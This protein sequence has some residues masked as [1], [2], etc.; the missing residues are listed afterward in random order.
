M[1]DFLD[2]KRDEIGARMREL[3][4][5]VDE[6]RR[7]EAAAAALSTVNGGAPADLPPT[8]APARTSSRPKPART[9]RRGR[10]KGSGKR[11][12]E[13]L[14]I[15]RANPGI[16]IPQIADKIGIKQNYLYRVLPAL[17]EDHLVKRDG[18]GWVPVQ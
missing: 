13:C 17:A 6:Y 14:T 18:K 8:A 11:A 3:E 15:V 12:D 4:P 10:P 7:L 1:A 16:T 2:A 5:S 9:G